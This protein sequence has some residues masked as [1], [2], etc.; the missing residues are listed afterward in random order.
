MDDRLCVV[1]VDDDPEYRTFMQL[2]LEGEGYR[3]VLASTTGEVR[4]LLAADRP[5]LVICDAR[6][7]DTAPFAVLDLLR[8]TPKAANIPVLLCTGAVAEVEERAADLAG[9]GV[10]VLTK[11]FDIDV[12]L[13]Q[14]AEL[15]GPPQGKNPDQRPE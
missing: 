7:P 13:R 10:K 8:G 6:L 4:G 15:C 12:L 3:T 2:L 11:P 9:A 5:H 1:V 14:V